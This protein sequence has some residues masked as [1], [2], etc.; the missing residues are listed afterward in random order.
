M[1]YRMHALLHSTIIAAYDNEPGWKMDG[2]KI[3]VDTKG[4]PIYVDGEGREMAVQHG[5]LASLR[6]EAQTHRTAKE[7][8]ETEL[9]KYRD[10]T[11]KLVDPETA[12]KSIK[13]VADID[14]KKLIDAG[15]VDKVR[16]QI[17]SEFT[18]LITERDAA[19][20]ERDTKINNM[21]IDSVF[22]GS[23]FIVDRVNMPRDFF[24]AAMRSNFRVEDGKV[25][26]YDSAGNRLM[27][28]KNL[29]DTPAPDEALELLVDAHPQRDTILKAPQAGGTGGNG[30]GGNRGHG[31]VIKRSEFD[32]GTAQQ[33]IAWGK[34]Q[35]AGEVQIVD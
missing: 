9:A 33:Q 17:K 30:G 11:G 7:T 34:Q 1:T 21:L 19:L 16:D 13:L 15:E 18:N 27:S 24:E 5:T 23:E 4:D 2:D 6:R 31:R 28:K 3:A 8:A 10:E 35:S 14:A 29:G 25:I 32:A 22:K 12:K 20:A 26:A